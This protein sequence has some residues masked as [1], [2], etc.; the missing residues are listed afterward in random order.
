MLYVIATP[1]TKVDRRGRAPGHFYAKTSR[2]GEK[3]LDDMAGRLKGRGIVA[4]YAAD[5]HAKQ[6][7]RLATALACNFH[8]VRHLRGF[9]FGRFA[10]HPWEEVSRVL[11]DMFRHWDCN[12]TIPV[13]GGDSWISYRRRF[14]EEMTKLMDRENILILVHPFDLHMFQKMMTTTVGQPYRAMDPDSSVINNRTRG[15]ILRV[16]FSEHTASSGAQSSGKVPERSGAV[17][18]DSRHSGNHASTVE[19]VTGN[20]NPAP[21]P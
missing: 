13:V 18:S 11:H 10:G 1:E 3:Y 17:A 16:N 9:N 8:P 20:N 21:G 12:E 15:K 2:E 4:V 6:G 7:E 14:F 5:I 19:A